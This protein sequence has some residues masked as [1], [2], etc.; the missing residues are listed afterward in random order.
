MKKRQKKESPKRELFFLFESSEES[1]L[2]DLE[3]NSFFD[4]AHICLPWAA[5]LEDFVT[6]PLV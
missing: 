6:F 5:I 4:W 1:A 3:H 2:R